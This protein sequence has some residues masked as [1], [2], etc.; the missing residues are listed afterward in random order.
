MSPVLTKAIEAYKEDEYLYRALLKF[1]R[2]D[3]YEMD[4]YFYFIDYPEL[5][6]LLIMIATESGDQQV[7]REIK[8]MND[9]KTREAQNILVHELCCDVGKKYF[10]NNSVFTHSERLYELQLRSHSFP[11][12]PF[13][14]LFDAVSRD[15][16]CRARNLIL[17]SPPPLEIIH[18]LIQIATIRCN[19]EMKD[20]FQELEFEVSRQV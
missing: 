3:F 15:N 9:Q 14:K 7:F 11:G 17:G 10:L 20:L 18:N 8:K 6:D 12:L 4:I 5:H 19:E 2:K 13:P 1:H 16:I